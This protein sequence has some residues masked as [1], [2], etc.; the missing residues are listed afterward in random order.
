MQSLHALMGNFCNLSLAV[1]IFNACST[2]SE[3]LLWGEG[4]SQQCLPV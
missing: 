4:H 1:E 3:I 2:F